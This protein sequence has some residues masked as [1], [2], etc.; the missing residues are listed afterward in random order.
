MSYV[1][2]M[3]TVGFISNPAIGTAQFEN[4]QLCIEAGDTFVAETNKNRRYGYICVQSSPN[5]PPEK[6]P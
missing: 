6:K 4:K 1:L 2:I 3:F 5:N